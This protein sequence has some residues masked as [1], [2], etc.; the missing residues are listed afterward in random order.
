MIKKNIKRYVNKAILLIA[1]F[2]FILSFAQQE[3]GI[4]NI[5]TQNGH[6]VK[7][8]ASGFNVRI[9]DK[10]W[11]YTHPDFRET[12]HQLKPGWL[13]YFSGTMGDAFSSATGQY[14]IDY[15]MMFNH[16]K[17]YLKGYR[18]TEVKG[19]HRIIDLYD[20]LS[21]I[22][23]KLIVT[24]NGFS[25]TP[26]M[27]K[28]LARFCKNNNIEVATWQFCNEPYFYV[29][30]RGLYW[31]NNGYD[32]AAKMKPHADA[33]REVFPDAYLALNCTWDG[34]WGFMKEINQYQKEHG[35][36]WNVFSKH[37]Y[38]PHTGKKESLDEAYRRGN[39]KILEATSPKA[40]QE[41]EDYTWEN[42]PMV[43]TEF[44]VWNTPLNGIY[45][46]IYNIEYVMR[47]LQHTNTWYIGA[48]EISSKFQP[49]KNINKQIEEAYQNGTILKTD[50]IS[51]GIKKTLEGK[52]YEIFHNV[53]NHTDFVFESTV[54]NGFN[55]PGMKNTNK[56]GFYSQAYRGINGYNYLVFT[57]RTSQS[58]DF[59]INVDGKLLNRKIETQFIH[60]DSLQVQNT[61]I[62]NKV[63][64]NGSLN[65]PAYSVTVAKWKSK[66]VVKPLS[67]VVYKG[68]VKKSGIKLT[69]GAVEN[70]NSYM[71]SYG[72]SINDLNHKLKVRKGT[73]VEINNLENGEEYY[74]RMLAKNKLGESEYSNHIK[75]K[76]D[77]PN[78]PDIFKTSRRNN[79]ATVFWK[80]VAN[81]TAYK[82]K[83]INTKTS[84]ENIIDVNNVYGY[85]VEGL[86]YD[87][88][89]Q[90]SVAAYNGFGVGEYSKPVRL[91]L[92]EKVPLS[93]RNVSAIRNQEGNVL[94]K[95]ITQ[96][97]VDSETTYNVY[98]GEKLHHYSKIAEGINAS[99]Y[100][101]TTAIKDKV[102]YYTVKA[103]T[104]AG[105]S[106]FYPNS[107]TLIDV[108]ETSSVRIDKVEK[109]KDGYLFYVSYNNVLLDGEYSYGLKIEN[110]SYLTVE[111]QLLNGVDLH[112]TDKTFKV[113]ISNS[114]LTKKSKYAVKAFIKT[115]GKSIYSKLPNKTIVTD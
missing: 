76:F 108:K 23:G 5:N 42:V 85:R 77:K 21:E 30:H 15:A 17:Q 19:P 91:I 45:S 26:E 37:S 63:C 40:M 82:L 28:E 92:S 13:R 96:N 14:D 72:K 56:V 89:Y 6:P 114:E 94:V 52:A 32:Y 25:E 79:T 4:I 84:Q 110:I 22:N 75:L 111:E 27:T 31:W 55:A 109:Q 41:I 3:Q 61:D 50:S 106:N 93:P 88:V 35:A 78:T 105:E 46:S 115:N 98:R 83:Y 102:Y 20:L 103:E 68:E 73:S 53:T 60:A 8:G 9:A 80:S 39:S 33:I 69:W 7:V 49:K 113:F 48:H 47:Q 104:S 87:V 51:T 90:F 12:V 67:P 97:D 54:V 2:S 24:V 66:S 64:K 59:T 36:Y 107:A 38:A 18:F 99:S 58:K 95:W 74:F 81:T 57:N 10:S 43:I 71:V 34:I 1:L 62:I 29:P 44:G 101:D 16:S 70:A 86:A 11:N 100:I 112:T 65:I